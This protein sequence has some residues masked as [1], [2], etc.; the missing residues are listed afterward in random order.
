VVSRRL[1]S[2]LD[3]LLW[4]T[5]ASNH[6]LQRNDDYVLEDSHLYK[7]TIGVVTHHADSYLMAKLPKDGTYYVHL[8]DAQ[9]H[10]GEAYAYRLRV[11][12]PQPDF[13][14]RVTPSSLSVNAGGTVA[15]C[16]YVL[17]KDGFDGEIEVALKDAPAGF[18]LTAGRIP[19]GRDRIRM[20]L[21]V[22]VAAPA[23][24]V[25]VQLEGIAKIGGQAIH[26]PIVPAEDKMQAFLY[27]HL[28]PSQELLVCVQ[29]A[30]WPM[31][32][33][34]LAVGGPIRIPVGGAAQ[35]LFKTPRRPIWQEVQ[36][37]LQEPP[38]GV[39]LHGVA[40]VSEGLTFQL[41]A[42]K[43]ATRSGL[44]DNLIV[45]AYREVTPARQGGKPAPQ[46]RRTSVGIL[47]AIPIEIVQQ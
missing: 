8:G 17:R 23:Q 3:S 7:D 10:G 44:V 34:R 29:K 22:P 38:A 46:K 5:D 35:V 28:V 13:A 18:S 25:A 42:D 37:E 11:S 19:P 43:D 20:T 6:V 27:R 4:L 12:A 36:L 2:P 31:P 39:T 21:T 41:R 47:P 32:P 45:Q 9:H 24:P 40:V 14:L 33:V 1:N 30:R 15:V 26:R 16:V